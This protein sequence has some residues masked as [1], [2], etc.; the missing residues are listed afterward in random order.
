[1]G[2]QFFYRIV[3]SNNFPTIDLRK[4]SAAINFANRQASMFHIVVKVY[5][6]TFDGDCHGI[7][8]TAY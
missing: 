4:K 2:S 8:H 1:M 7:I 6:Y 3:H 5:E